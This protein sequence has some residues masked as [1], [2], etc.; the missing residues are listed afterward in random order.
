[1]DDGQQV[2][3]GGVVL[4]TDSFKSEDISTLRDALKNNF[5]LITSIHNKKSSSS[6]SSNIYERIYINKSSLDEIKPSLKEYMHSSMFYKINETLN[7]PEK[8]QNHSDIS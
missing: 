4:C 7:V 8:E 6:E 1:M 3:K 2:K 5:N